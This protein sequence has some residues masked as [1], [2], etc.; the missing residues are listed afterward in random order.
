MTHQDDF[1]W[2]TVLPDTSQ[3]PLSLRLM[4]GSSEFYPQQEGGFLWFIHIHSSSTLNPEE[5]IWLDINWV[6]CVSG[7]QGLAWAKCGI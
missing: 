1:G 7:S 3:G 2:A 6:Q 5:W 4:A